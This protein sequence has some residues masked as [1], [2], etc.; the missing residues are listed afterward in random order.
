MGEAH[1]LLTLPLLFQWDAYLVPISAS[2]VVFISHDGYIDVFA[3][4][5]DEYNRLRDY[6]QTGG[7]SLMLNEAGNPS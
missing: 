1:S 3:E 2:F 5:S 7:W 4:S 6:F